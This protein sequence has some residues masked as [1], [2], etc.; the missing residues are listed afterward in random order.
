M[1]YKLNQK[2]IKPRYILCFLL[3]IL[4]SCSTYK[5][6]K[7]ATQNKWLVYNIELKGL[8][9]AENLMLL[10]LNEKDST[11]QIH[12]F[13]YQNSEPQRLFSRIT[14][15]DSYSFLNGNYIFP[16]TLIF[17]EAK[18]GSKR[19]IKFPLDQNP[20][21]KYNKKLNQ[22][23]V[24]NKALNLKKEIKNSEILN[25]IELHQNWKGEQVNLEI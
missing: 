7:S 8:G 10:Q 4:I 2:L 17:N 16:T 19:T 1:K 21:F 20:T 15:K 13:I 6:V 14:F 9:D 18:L 23:I 11:F 3:L 25:L 24:F 22:L 12:W 5:N